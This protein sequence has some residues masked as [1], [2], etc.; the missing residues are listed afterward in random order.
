[1]SIATRLSGPSWR[2]MRA[3]ER[4]LSDDFKLSFRS[5]S[6][7]N[8]AFA[9]IVAR[10]ASDPKVR[11]RGRRK[12]NRAAVLNALILW[13]DALPRD[14]QMLVVG[15]GMRRLNALLLPDSDADGDIVAAA[16]DP[17]A[18]DIP[19]PPPAGEPYAVRDARAPKPP[20]RRK[21]QG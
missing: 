7:V 2:T 1:M 20:G 21:G 14:Q 13:L 6:E 17:A 8:E 16:A 10:A 12:A 15:D 9:G 3:M 19:A 5:L 4:D 11:Y 18:T